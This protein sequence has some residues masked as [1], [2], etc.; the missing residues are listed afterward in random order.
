ARDTIVL[1]D[2]R[3]LEDNNE[4]PKGDPENPL[5]AAELVAKFKSLTGGILAKGEADRIVDKVMNLEK[6]ADVN[7]LLG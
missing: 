2:G 1:S 3:N 7:E 5:T 4:Y 6:I